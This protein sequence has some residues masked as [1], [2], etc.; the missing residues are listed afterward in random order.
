MAEQL[1]TIYQHFDPKSPRYYITLEH[2]IQRIREGRS[3]KLIDRIRL[4]GNPELKKQLSCL[5]FSGQFTYRNRDSL[6]AHSGLICLDFDK[7]PDLDT[8]QAYRDS[9]QDDQY[10]CAL[11]LS[12]SGTGLKVIVRIPPEPEH[13]K[14][15]FDSLADYY[16]SPYFD[17]VCSDVCR[18]CFESYDQ[19]VYFNPL[20]AVYTGKKQYAAAADPT[21]PSTLDVSETV[22]RLLLWSSR[23]Y[24]II[25]G[26]RNANMFKVAASFN[27]FGVSRSEAEAVLGQFAQDGF[28]VNEIERI[29]NNAYKD[30]GKFGRYRW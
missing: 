20:C 3:R 5:L 30:A 9:L 7:F 21:G 27:D 1:I 11:F 15:R 18:I 12:P 14:A 23:K 28:P 16:G 29:I 13:H 10:T 22:R 19:D 17:R 2:A 24:P 25:D 4:T 8:L 6:V 26:Q